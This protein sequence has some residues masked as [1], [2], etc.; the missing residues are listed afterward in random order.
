MS[1]GWRFA[2]P[3]LAAV[4]IGTSTGIT[5]PLATAAP[6]R[7]Q[8]DPSL[9]AAT[10]YYVDPQGS[11]SAD[12]RTPATAW[13]SLDKVNAQT[14]QPGDTVSFKAGGT[15]TGQ[16]TPHGSG[17]KA[18]PVTLTS[19][20]TGAKP[21]I[22]GGGSVDATIKLS[23]LHDVVVDGFEVTNTGSG[24]TPRIGIGVSATDQ[25]AVPGITIRNNKVHAIQGA[26][27]G[28]QAS[29]PSAGGIIVAALGKQ[30]PTYYDNLQIEDNEVYDSRSYGI[31]TWSQW[32]QR[33]GWNYLWT[34][35]MGIPAADYR[36]WT[37]S[38]HVVVEGNSVHDIS[39][40]GIT[41]MQAQGARIEHN[42][43]DKT[44]QNHGNVGIWWAGADDTMVQYNDVSGTKYWG[45][46]SDGT[47]FDADASVH[48]SVVQHNFSHD[49]EGGFFIAVSTASAPAEATIRYNVSQGDANQVF[50]LSTNAKNIDI[51][52]NTIWV[53][54]TP[55]IA[56]HPDRASFSLVKVWNTTVKDVRFR[57]NVI[58]NGAKLPYNDQNLVTYD[59]NLYQ[60]G[61]V[62]SDNSAITGDAK[63]TAPGAAK[64]ITDLSGYVPTANSPA[65]AA[66]LD[67][68]ND[69]GRD[70]AGTKLPSGMPDIG[71]RQRT[72]GP[73]LDEAAPTAATTFGD[74]QSSTPAALTDGSDSTT[75]ASPSSGVTYPGSITLTFPSSRTVSEVVLATHFGQGQ[76]ITKADVQT[77]NGSAWV[78]QA[79]DAAVT[80]TSNNAT[81][82]RQSI[83]LPKAVSTTQ[84][85]LVVK[86]ANH[87][88]GNLSANE[89]ST[90]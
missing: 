33:E 55:F 25:G 54:L 62:P 56:N 49:N 7:D 69:G 79:T 89:I 35:L 14:F 8:G 6:A 4:L 39:A 86:A 61:P 70:T 1:R 78:T 20:G 60:D 68:A 42:R 15:W 65:I 82:E 73:G 53:P 58:Y 34:D 59:R 12:G 11:D 2:G 46:A 83:R 71:G 10:S 47:A 67:I 41:V 76:G 40:G 13:K 66:G 81:V 38:T 48:R 87:T 37:P 74:G 5:A 52:N 23:N 9:K 45:L 21:R 51:Y 32:M 17:T 84:L 30:T 28:G 19:Y 26:S 44:A 29:N 72:A 88:W 22:D 27:S 85:R 24:T 43:V 36:P 57:N 64:Q 63:L 75:W 16:F 18:S 80:W 77:W 31:V 50:A 3:A 90:R